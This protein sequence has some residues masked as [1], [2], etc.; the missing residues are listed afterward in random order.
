MVSLSKWYSIR[1]LYRPSH[2]IR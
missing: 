2:P 1:L